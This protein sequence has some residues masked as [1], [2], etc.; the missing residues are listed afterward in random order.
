MR[1]SEGM[2]TLEVIRTLPLATRMVIDSL[3]KRSKDK[4]QRI[5]DQR[6]ALLVEAIEALFDVVR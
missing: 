6:A 2:Q 4:N 3:P 1:T 5:E